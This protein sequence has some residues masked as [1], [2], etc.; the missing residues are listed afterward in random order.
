MKFTH[1]LVRETAMEFAAEFYE[2]A[3]HD[4]MFYKLYKNQKFFI[5]KTWHMFIDRAIEALTMMLS[6]NTDEGTKELIADAL[7]KHN[8]IKAMI[9]AEGQSAMVH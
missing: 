8:E 2:E 6:S 4:D 3:A 1:R 7:I 5:Q 9:P